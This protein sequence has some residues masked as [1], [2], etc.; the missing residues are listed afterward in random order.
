MSSVGPV[1]HGHLLPTSGARG[2]RACA[3]DCKPI[4]TEASR[5]GPW[6]RALLKFSTH[7]FSRKLWLPSFEWFSAFP[8]IHRCGQMVAVLK[9]VRKD[10]NKKSGRCF[11]ILATS[12][13]PS[14]LISIH[15]NIT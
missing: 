10:L 12:G 6:L 14:Y 8:V 1:R 7:D 13:Y 9:C 11:N 4:L 5:S 15:S 2:I 3:R